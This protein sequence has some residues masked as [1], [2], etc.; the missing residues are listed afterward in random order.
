VHARTAA[1]S[2]LAAEQLRAA[3]TVDA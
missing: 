2:D 1:Q 3:Y